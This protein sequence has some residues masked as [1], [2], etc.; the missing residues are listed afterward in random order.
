MDPHRHDEVANAF[1]L[2]GLRLRAHMVR[3]LVSGLIEYEC[4]DSDI[5]ASIVEVA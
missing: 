4:D 2:A 5:L 3:V 1:Y